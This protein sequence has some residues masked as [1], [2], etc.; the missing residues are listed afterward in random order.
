[1]DRETNAIEE[2]LGSDVSKLPERMH[3]LNLHRQKCT[4]THRHTHILQE[5]INRGEARNANCTKI[6]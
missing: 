3:V 5:E 6:I 1:M 4:N 2:S